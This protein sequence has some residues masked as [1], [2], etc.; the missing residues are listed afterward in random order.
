MSRISLKKQAARIL[1]GGRMSELDALPPAG[2]LR[3]LLPLISRPD[4]EL[5]WAAVEAL[6]RAAA[7]QVEDDP[8]PVREI[9]RRLVWSL[10]DESGSIGW[11]AA[12]AMAEI[13]DAAPATAGDFAPLL[14]SLT[15]PDPGAPDFE[16]LNAGALWA[17]GRLAGTRPELVRNAARHLPRFFTSP[18]AR[19]RGL[20][21]WSAGRLGGQ[22][23]LMEDLRQAAKDLI[24]DEAVLSLRRRGRTE[25]T[26]VGLLAAEAL[27]R[28]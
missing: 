3:A 13:I 26:T 11:G 23:S 19:L 10:N 8:E 5:R 17:V 20:A 7:R 6:G 9:L 28:L 16:P 24:G 14:A 15:A 4:E 27:D 18:H 22:T 25:T 2:L 12:E 21:V 1:A